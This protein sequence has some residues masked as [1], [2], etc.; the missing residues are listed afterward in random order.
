MKK[1][2]YNLSIILLGNFLYSM[3][4]AFFILPVGLITGGTAG[5]AISVQHYTGL[6]VSGFVTIFNIAM[7]LLGAAVLGRKFAMTTLVSTFV[8]PFFLQIGEI[9]VLCCGLYLQ[10]FWSEQVSGW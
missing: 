1:R 5:I 7:F 8:Y 3:A 2:I 4:V 10:E 6:P 9:L